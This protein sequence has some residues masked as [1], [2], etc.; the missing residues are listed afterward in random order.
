LDKA[1]ENLAFHKNQLQ[2]VEQER[3]EHERLVDIVH[4]ILCQSITKLELG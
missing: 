2:Q 1:E 4:L 3:D